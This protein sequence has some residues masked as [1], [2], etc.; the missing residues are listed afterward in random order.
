MI[1]KLMNED[2]IKETQRKYDFFI[3]SNWLHIY[4]WRGDIVRVRRNR[5]TASDPTRIYEIIQE[6]YAL[7]QPKLSEGKGLP[8]EI[9]NCE[10]D[11]TFKLPTNEQ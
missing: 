10:L 6:Y 2:S 1:D 11:K 7:P 4:R 9:T 3:Y 8:H 5:E